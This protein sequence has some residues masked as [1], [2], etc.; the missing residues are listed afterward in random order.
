V[1]IIEISE[2][3]HREIG[4]P[5]DIAQS[6]ITFWLRAN[7][8]KLSNLIGADYNIDP[9]TYE[10]S[11]ELGEGEKAILKELYF[12]SYYDYLINRNTGASGYGSLVEVT[13]DGATVRRVAATEVTRGYIQ[14]RKDHSLSL[15][16]LVN[17]FKCGNIMPKQVAGDDTRFPVSNRSNDYARLGN[18]LN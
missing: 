15:K 5:S 1:K 12:I 6:Y 3:L 14:L 10:I 13:S 9:D 7:V 11:P 18:N 8:G 4:A 2:E 16:E 17:G